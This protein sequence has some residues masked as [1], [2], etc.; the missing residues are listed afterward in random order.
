MDKKFNLNFIDLYKYSFIDRIF[1][2]L[3]TRALGSKI[4]RLFTLL[5]ALINSNPN[6]KNKAIERTK[7]YLIETIAPKNLAL[8][9]YDRVILRL[10][11][12]KADN[13][14]F[15]QD[16]QR[17]FDILTQDIQLYGLVER[18]LGD[19]S[20]REMFEEIIKKQFDAQYEIDSE[21]RNILQFQE[22]HY[23]S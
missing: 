17:A 16:R 1:I 13:N 3:Q 7:A 8:K 2:R 11:D 21:G 9:V 6:D 20:K 5:P 19:A 15:I 23:K 12:Y 22:R 10:L 18:I 14:L 4:E